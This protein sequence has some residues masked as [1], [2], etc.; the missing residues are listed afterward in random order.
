MRNNAQH[1]IWSSIMLVFVLTSAGCAK[2]NSS[3]NITSA[4]CYISLMNMA[5]YSS[6]VDISFNGTIVTESGGIKAGVYSTSYGQAKPGSYTVDF[7][8][9]GTDS[10]LYEIPAMMYDTNAFYTLILYNTA[11]ESPA[12]AAARI[13]DDYSSVT[14]TNNAYYRF[15]NLSPDEANVDLYL[16]GTA[17]Q[18]NR[19]PMDMLINQTLD[20]FQPINPGTYNISVYK[21]NTD[22]VLASLNPDELTPGTVYTIFLAGSSSNLTITSLAATY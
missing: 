5:P 16:G 10:L 12:V 1:F 8:V 15:F 7:K 2:T 9:A 19:T 13:A 22:T 14:Q 18:T 11:P 3:N 6:A 17:E 20:G 4:V 21:A